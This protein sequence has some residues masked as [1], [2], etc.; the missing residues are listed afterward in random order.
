MIGRLQKHGFQWEDMPF[1]DL[2]EQYPHCKS[3]LSWW[4][5]LN[6]YHTLN[7]DN[8]RY[9][10]DFL[11]N[12][13]P[14]FPIS[15]KCCKYSKKDASNKVI[16][17]LG[18]DLVLLGIRKSEGGIRSIA[19]NSCFDEHHHSGASQ[20]RPIFWYTNRDKQEYERI[21]G[22]V[23][24][25]CYTK[26]GFRRTGCCCCPF[27]KDFENELKIVQE[28]EPKLYRAVSNIFGKSYEYT[29]KYKMYCKMRKAYKTLYI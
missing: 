21:F 7:I 22:I 10:K 8:N 19:F 29:R 2:Y 27:G 9:L 1:E 23:H 18:I 5:N 15:D 14:D 28:Y 16:K 26:Y 3:A 6:R 17:D 11:I 12:N 20:Y 4:C 25:D 13:P 24:S